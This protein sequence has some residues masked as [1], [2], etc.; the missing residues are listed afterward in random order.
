MED[1]FFLYGKS[2]EVTNALNELNDKIHQYCP[3]C[4]LSITQEKGQNIMDK[5]HY[6]CSKVTDNPL[7]CI[8]I[9]DKC[10]SSLLLSMGNNNEISYCSKTLEELR[11]KKLNKL[12][13]AVL[14]IIAKKNE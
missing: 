1:E 3:N 4:S 7:L 6:G 11:N 12:L 2:P 10:V 8:N 5:V 14:F 13:R 9:G